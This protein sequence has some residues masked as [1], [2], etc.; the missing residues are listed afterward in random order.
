VTRVGEKE[1]TQNLEER[2]LFQKGELEDREVDEMLIF[3]WVSE[4]STGRW[5]VH[6][7]GLVFAVLNL[8]A[9][10]PGSQLPTKRRCQ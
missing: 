9:P 10:L 4:Q 8:L 3:K 5:E 1:C 7:S 2:N 6:I